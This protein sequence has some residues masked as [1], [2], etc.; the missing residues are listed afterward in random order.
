[1]PDTNYAVLV[2]VMQSDGTGGVIFHG[3]YPSSTTDVNVYATS[4]ARN[5]GDYPMWN[6]VIFG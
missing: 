1:M 4:D 6:V 2:N 3:G 5:G